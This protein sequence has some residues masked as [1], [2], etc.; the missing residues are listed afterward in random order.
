MWLVHELE[1]I[2][3]PRYS[4][5][6]IEYRRTPGI[7]CFLSFLYTPNTQLQLGSVYWK[8]SN[9]VH[10]WNRLFD[11][12]DVTANRGLGPQVNRDKRETNGK[13]LTVLE[14]MD[15]RNDSSMLV[16][17]VGLDQIA[18]FCKGAVGVGVHLH[19]LNHVDIWA[20]SQDSEMR[21][22]DFSK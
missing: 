1:P 18:R 2:Y 10:N 13:F 22:I 4:R 16:G 6:N 12:I 14:N 19:N 11:I 15:V 5:K 17:R 21:Y 8:P 7:A 3:P 9:N 20:E